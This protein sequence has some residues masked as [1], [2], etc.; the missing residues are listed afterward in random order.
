MLSLLS[1][2]C[3]AKSVLE[4]VHRHGLSVAYVSNN[5]RLSKGEIAEW[6]VCHSGR[7]YLFQRLLPA[8]INFLNLSDEDS[9]HHFHQNNLDVTFCKFTSILN[10]VC[11]QY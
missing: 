2:Y 1:R 4:R 11:G 5:N 8:I 7:K 10:C 3:V 9:N 6:M